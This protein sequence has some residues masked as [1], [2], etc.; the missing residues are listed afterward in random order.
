MIDKKI[1]PPT[2]PVLERFSSQIRIY[3]SEKVMRILR[4][5]SDKI[6]RVAPEE[7]E[8]IA[9]AIE[10]NKNEHHDI[11]LVFHAG[12]TP[13]YWLQRWGSSPGKTPHIDQAGTRWI[14]STGKGS[15]V[16]RALTPSFYLIDFLWA[17]RSFTWY[18]EE[19]RIMMLKVRDPAVERCDFNVFSE[20]IIPIVIG[21]GR[22]EWEFTRD[23]S[24]YGCYHRSNIKFTRDAGE[25]FVCSGFFG[26]HG[27]CFWSFFPHD[28]LY[29]LGM[30]LAWKVKTFI[31]EPEK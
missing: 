7:E 23:R 30:T 6:Y 24:G 31:L 17:S 12:T 15:W 25:Q 13:Y 5:S 19:D 20:S 26:E 29:H 11:R 3:G 27:L 9:K 14:N 4:V 22:W 10:R 21:G 2:D 1:L 8:K 16:D 18:Q 28:T